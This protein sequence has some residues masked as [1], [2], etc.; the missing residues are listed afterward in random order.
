MRIRRHTYDVQTIGKFVHSYYKTKLL[1][2]RIFKYHF[3]PKRMREAGNVAR[4][5]DMIRVYKILESLKEIDHLRY[6]MGED[7]RIIL[8]SICNDTL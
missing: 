6:V 7:G 8:K 4:T 3:K 2:N 1:L 5:R